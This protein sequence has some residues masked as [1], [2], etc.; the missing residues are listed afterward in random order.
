[1]AKHELYGAHAVMKALFAVL[2]SLP[3]LFA[4]LGSRRIVACRMISDFRLK[5]SEG[6][7][8]LHATFEPDFAGTRLPNAHRYR[9]VPPH[10]R[11]D[12][13]HRPVDPDQEAE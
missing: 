4:K 6:R 9:A 8:N 11:P 12:H 5:Q 10:R 1:M 3:S 13:D 7:V 2:L